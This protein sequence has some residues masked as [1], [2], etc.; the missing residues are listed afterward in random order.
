MLSV[1]N[2]MIGHGSMSPHG[3]MWWLM[4]VAAGQSARCYLHGEEA[5]PERMAKN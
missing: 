1:A 2:W 5:D 4:P 3:L